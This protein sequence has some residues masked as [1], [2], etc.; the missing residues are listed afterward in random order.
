MGGLMKILFNFLNCGL[1]NNGGCST[2][3]NSANTLAKLGHDIKIISS[4]KNKFT[5]VPLEVPHLIIE[6]FNKVPSAD[7]IIATGFNTVKST[8]DL[9]SRCGLKCHWIRAWE[10]WMMNESEII[11]KILNVPTFKIVNSICLRDK[12]KKHG[13]DS[14]IIRPGY[15]FDKIIPLGIRTYKEPVILGALYRESVHGERKRTQWVLDAATNI[16]S[17]T[18]NVKLWM[19]GSEPNP[20]LEVIDRYVRL[21]S[22][23]KKN[24]FYNQVN[25][26]LAPTKSEGLHLPP[27]EAMLTKCPIVGTSA[28]LSGMQ[29]YLIHKKTGLISDNTF[30]SFVKTITKMIGFFYS[31]KLQEMGRSCRKQILNLGSRK[32][33]MKKLVKLLENNI[34]KNFQFDKKIIMP[35]DKSATPE[36]ISQYKQY[37]PVKYNICKQQNPKIMIEIGV[38]AGYSAWTFLQACPNMKYIGIDANNGKFGGQGGKDGSYSKWAKN[39]LKPYDVTLIDQDTQKVDK[40]G[41]SQID[42]IHVDGD[43][44]SE[45]V[46]HDLDLAYEAVKIGGTILVD[47]ITYIEEVKIGVN[48]WL[49]KMNKFITSTFI[50][51]FRGEMLITR[52]I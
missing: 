9:P 23:T 19:F 35:G 25:I 26:W 46:Q 33:N 16:K 10:H 4:A 44:T 15:D 37:Y 45:G 31:G 38:R 52:N 24:S 5:W 3:V 50:E 40:L 39:I 6:D 14:H 18:E 29:E 2:I 22:M 1:G 43:H 48:I 8:L 12:L 32:D 27:A 47:D 42:F 51:S 13:I 20:N 41:F 36:R 11:S 17:N 34:S 30:D 28:E 49:R 7:V 21:P